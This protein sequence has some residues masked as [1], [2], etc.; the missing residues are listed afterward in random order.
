MPHKP[1]AE[2][3]LSAAMCNTLY[4]MLYCF[5]ILGVHQYFRNAFLFLTVITMVIV[6]Q[7]ML[8]F[9]ICMD[10]FYNLFA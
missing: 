1:Y 6:M 2:V 5:T 7:I 9:E 4:A 10:F 8:V 3:F